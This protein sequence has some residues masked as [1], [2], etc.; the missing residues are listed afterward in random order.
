MHADHILLLSASVMDLQKILDICCTDFSAIGF[1]FN[2]IKSKCMCVG[3]N[4]HNKPICM[5][6]DNVRLE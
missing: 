1:K 5:K 4:V 2:P 3:P 6:L